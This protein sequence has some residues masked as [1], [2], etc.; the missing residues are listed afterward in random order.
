MAPATNFLPRSRP[1]TVSNSSM[2]PRAIACGTILTLLR[3]ITALGCKVDLLS[4]GVFGVEYQLWQ[5]LAWLQPLGAA[6]QVNPTMPNGIFFVQRPDP[7]T[8]QGC[9]LNALIELGR[10]LGYELAACSLATAFF[11]PKDVWPRLG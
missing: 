5:A 9:S 7:D 4:L 3:P 8:H 6:G 1:R 2:F 11:V 10:G